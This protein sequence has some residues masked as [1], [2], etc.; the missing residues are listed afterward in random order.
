MTV[1]H[2]AGKQ[3][4]CNG[5]GT[6]VFKWTNTYKTHYSDNKVKIECL[7]RQI[8]LKLVS[9][10]K[11]IHDGKGEETSVLQFAIN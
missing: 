9:K 10:I 6:S 1:V 3:G 8:E 2:V 4:Q 5:N 11:N 7:E